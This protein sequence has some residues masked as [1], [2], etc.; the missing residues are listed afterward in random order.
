MKKPMQHRAV[1]KIRRAVLANAVAYVVATILV[2]ALFTE[3]YYYQSGISM[4]GFVFGQKKRCEKHEVIFSWYRWIEGENRFP[5]TG[6]DPNSTMEYILTP[7]SNSCIWWTGGSKYCWH[8]DC[9]RKFEK[10]SVLYT[11]AGKTGW[12]KIGV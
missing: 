9:A 4:S 8:G 12:S 1:N 11:I 7:T 3:V 2:V 5:E 10:W 6:F